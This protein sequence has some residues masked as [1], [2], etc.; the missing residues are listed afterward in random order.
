ST[1][2]FLRARGRRPVILWACAFAATAL[3]SLAGAAYHYWRVPWA[4]VAIMTGAAA[5]CFGCAIAVA[6]LGPA[7][8]RIAIALLIV[9]FAACVVASAMSDS[10]VVVAADYGPVLLMILM[11]CLVRWRDRAARFIAAGIVVAFV[12]LGV[13]ASS[14]RIGILDH[15]DLFHVVQ[16]AAMFL[17]YRGGAS[18][19]AAS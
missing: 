8:R 18:L 15:N 17:L 13:E 19:S 10:F 1:L 16:M 12:A 14:W 9:E 5:L 7:A 11:G 4:L 3:G 6:W 2:L